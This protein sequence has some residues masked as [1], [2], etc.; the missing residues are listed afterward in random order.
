MA[1]E[2]PIHAHL[3]TVDR[4]VMWPG[5]DHRLKHKSRGA[6]AALLEQGESGQTVTHHSCGAF[7]PASAKNE[8]DRLRRVLP[9]SR[10]LGGPAHNSTSLLL[11][12]DLTLEIAA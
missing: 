8:M 1:A 11:W 2:Y 4:G 10:V 7:C 3:A 12:T 5:Q 9:E 6:V